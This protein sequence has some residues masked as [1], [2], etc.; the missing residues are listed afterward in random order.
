MFHCALLI[1]VI[2]YS[3]RRKYAFKIFSGV[4]KI[5]S[6]LLLEKRVV[7]YHLKNEGIWLNVYTLGGKLWKNDL[8]TQI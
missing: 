4:E 2:L 8:S 5:K 3:I 6:P 1:S 7:F